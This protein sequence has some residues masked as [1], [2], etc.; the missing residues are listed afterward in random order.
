MYFRQVFLIACLTALLA[1][2][3]FSVYQFAFVNPIIFA[4]ENFEIS[5]T[6]INMAVEPWSPEDGIERSFFTFLAN[7]LM[8]L[9]YGLILASAMAFRG[10]NSTLK[11]LAWGLAGYLTIFVAPSLGLPPEI[12]GMAA[13]ELSQRQNWWLLTVTLTGI[14]LAVLAFSPR[15]YK[16]AGIIFLI[17][18]HL[19][20][21]PNPA[22]HGFSH[23][24][25]NAVT[26]LMELWQQFI[27]Q[28][29]IANAL[30]WIIIGL[31]TGYLCR[32]FIDDVSSLQPNLID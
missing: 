22:I 32:K 15:Y 23:P 28:T 4:A 24:D 25:P 19:I 1:S 18:P 8:S 10:T 17:L 13:A 30:L 29:S 11:G 14:G 20:G 27:I 3:C 7:F 2:F 31:S 5:E 21:A 6:G 16:G 12:P 9:A 26:A